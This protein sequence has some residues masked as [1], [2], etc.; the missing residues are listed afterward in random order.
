MFG[1]G[2]RDERERVRTGG[3]LREELLL[4]LL[5]GVVVDV[6]GRVIGGGVI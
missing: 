4:S 1:V 3:R 2:S 6:E 5:V